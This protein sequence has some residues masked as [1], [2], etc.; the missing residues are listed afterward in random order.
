MNLSTVTAT[1]DKIRDLAEIPSVLD[2]LVD[3]YGLASVAYL[4]VDLPGQTNRD[5]LV[6]ATYTVEWVERYKSEGF[7]GIDPAI[8]TGFRQ[9]LPVDWSQ[10]ERQ[11][12]EVRRLFGEAAE[13]GLGRHGI[14]VPV[15]SGRGDKA[16]LSI[17]SGVPDRDWQ[18]LRP[19]YLQELPVIAL[20]MHD[21][22]MRL[23]SGSERIQPMLSP[24]E[25]ECLRWVGEGKTSW[26]CAV[27]LGISERTVRAYLETARQKLGAANT[28]HAVVK[29]TK[30]S[31]LSWLP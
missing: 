16:L 29:A 5:P 12:K 25:R 6:A 28:T 21:A 14:T 7:V 1:F 23:S 18:H 11:D 4:G 10:F 13:F 3:G 15:H 9:L 8:Q 24:R 22:L 19:R 30:S 2:R 26:E 20:H 31:L 27:I 17:T